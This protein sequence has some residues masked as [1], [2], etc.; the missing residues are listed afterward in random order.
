M[1]IV[2]GRHT[3]LTLLRAL[4]DKA[5]RFRSSRASLESVGPP[6]LSQIDLSPILDY[7]PSGHTLDILVG[8]HADR[9]DAK[10]ARIRIWSTTLPRHSLAQLAPGVQI[11]S[12]EFVFLQMAREWP[13]HD[14]IQLG[15]ELCGTYALAPHAP[16]GFTSR[17]NPLTTPERLIAFLKECPNATG[18]KKARRAAKYVIAGSASPMETALTMILCLP[19]LCGGFG[20]PQ[21]ALNKTMTLHIASSEAGRKRTRTCR[22]DL[23]WPDASLAIEY[24]SDAEHLSSQK[25]GEDSIRRNDL[26]STDITVLTVTKKQVLNLAHW[27]VLAGHVSAGLKIKPRIR[28][29]DHAKRQGELYA[30]LFGH[31][32]AEPYQSART[33]T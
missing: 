16:R 12:P 17:R 28:I 19:P 23:L 20:F 3:A 10:G 33:T 22:C 26:T 25:F 2:I 15:F 18:V 29:A 13:L 6:D 7:L 1:E 8:R 21:P 4:G 24:E 31:L 5:P 27:P 11:S 30:R 32:F 9:R 14:L